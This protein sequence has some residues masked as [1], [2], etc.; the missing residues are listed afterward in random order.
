MEDNSNRAITGT[1]QMRKLFYIQVQAVSAAELI[2]VA[3]LL[4]PVEVE[5][6]KEEEKG[7]E[8]IERYNHSNTI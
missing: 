5:K 8:E 6:E 1:G 2:I 4:A 7:R 3:V